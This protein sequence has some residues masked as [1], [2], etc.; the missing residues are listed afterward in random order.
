MGVGAS[1]DAGGLAAVAR[2]ETDVDLVVVEVG[3]GHQHG[4]DR[5]ECVGVRVLHVQA[6]LQARIVLL[7]GVAVDRDRSGRT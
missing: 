2:V 6:F 4:G 1:V 3:A 7:E 5:A